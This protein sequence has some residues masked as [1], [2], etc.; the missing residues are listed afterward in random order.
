MKIDSWKKI[1][2]M[3]RNCAAFTFAWLVIVVMMLCVLSGIKAIPVFFLL[4]LFV[5]CMA[6]SVIFTLSFSKVIIR[7][8]GFLFRLSFFMLCFVPCEVLGFYWM[9][10]FKSIGQSKQWML[11][12]GIIIVLYL[13]C[14]WIDKVIYKR[15]GEMYTFQLNEYQ[16]KRRLENGE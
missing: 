15:Q 1:A 8:K 6:L 9:G 10:I 12:S 13:V 2:A 5:L 16:K 4:K 3:F 11:F 7:K 14:I